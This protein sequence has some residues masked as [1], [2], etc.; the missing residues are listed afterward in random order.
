MFNKE[1][2]F[3]FNIFIYSIKKII[4]TKLIKLLIYIIQNKRLNLIGSNSK[5]GEK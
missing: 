1:I 2:F 5:S 4:K 3:F